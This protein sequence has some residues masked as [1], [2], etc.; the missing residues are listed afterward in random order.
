MVAIRK[1]L[2]PTDFSERSL[3][4]LPLAVDLAQRYGAELH[5]LHVVDMPD[6]FILEDSYMLP[7]ATEYQPDY[8]KLKQAAEAQIEQFV[9]QHMPDLRDSVRKVVILG[10]P[11]AEIIHYAREQGIDLIVLGTHGRSALGSMLLGSVAERVVRKA[12]CAVLTV[13]HPDHRFEA[14]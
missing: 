9:A 7:L 5:C 4:A 3:A 6:G 8:A 10:K 11:F 2:Y 1:V 12:P 13:R 14:P